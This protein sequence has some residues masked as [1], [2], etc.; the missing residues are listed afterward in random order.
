MTY[1]IKIGDHK[2]LKKFGDL[3]MHEFLVAAGGKVP[4]E[5]R[6]HVPGMPFW[7]ASA[8]IVGFIDLTTGRRRRGYSEMVW[9]ETFANHSTEDYFKAGTIYRIKGYV[10]EHGTEITVAEILSEGESDE[11]LEQL[12]KEFMEEWNKISKVRSDMFGKL[13]YDNTLERYECRFDWLG[14]K[15]WIR[16]DNEEDNAAESLRF[17]EEICRNCAEWDKKFKEA[18]VKHLFKTANDF[19]MDTEIT[20][21]E[22]VSRLSISS[23]SVS[24]FEGGTFHADYCSDGIFTDHGVVVSGNLVEG[25]EYVN[26]EG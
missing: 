24:D 5:N 26:L 13:D 23:I 2:E 14:K 10:K 20:E 4:A 9:K 7:L 15:C 11:Q 17:A 21:E 3:E 6:L 22:F 16:I 25:I 1:P 18:I 8:A 12:L 19:W